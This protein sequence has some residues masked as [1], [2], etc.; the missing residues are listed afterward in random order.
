LSDNRR[1][2][3]A[4]SSLAR[5]T[6]FLDEVQAQLMAFLRGMIGSDEEARDLLQDTFCSAWRIA[7]TGRPPFGAENTP[8]ERRRWLFH[9]AYNNAIS[10]LR[11]RRIIRW[12][13]LDDDVSMIAVSEGF[14]DRVAEEMALRSALATLPPSD[15]ACLLLVVVQGFTTSEAAQVIG[16]SPAAVAKRCLRAKQRLRSIYQ[17]Q[18]ALAEEKVS[19]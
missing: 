2:A 6:D 15:I 7:Q 9:V 12:E 11:H 5:F 14:E 16:I 18:N 13:S 17:A 8:I 1:Q 3:D 4:A 19:Q 10:A